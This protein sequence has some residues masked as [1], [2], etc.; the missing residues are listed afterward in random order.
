MCTVASLFLSYQW[1]LIILFGGDLLIQEYPALCQV[2]KVVIRKY[3]N[4][5]Q[6]FSVFLLE[7]LDCKSHDQAS[8][9]ILYRP[10]D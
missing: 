1:F 4:S 7:L 5:C 8:I 6:F 10:A 2:K 9:S 3:W